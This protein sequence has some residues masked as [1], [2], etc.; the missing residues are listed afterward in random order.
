MSEFLPVKPIYTG[1]D[2]TALGEAAP[3]DVMLSPGGGIKFP[4]GSLQITAGGSG[5]SGTLVEESPPTA[6]PTTLWFESDSGRMYLKYKNPDDA[7]VW[8]EANVAGVRGEVGPAGEQGAVGPA[9]PQGEIGLTG[10]AGAD[11]VAGP[12]GADGAVG[13]QGPAGA[14]GVAGPAGADGA[15]GIQGE[16]GPQGPAGPADWYAIPNVPPIA[17]N[18]G[19]T[20]G[21]NITGSAGTA[22]TQPKSSAG[23]VPAST[24]FAK[25]LFSSPSVEGV[26]DWNDL[27]NCIPG[28]GPT[29][30]MGN[31]PNGPGGDNYY[32]S[33]CVEYAGVVGAGNV[34]QMAICYSAP[35]NEMYMRG[36]YG[37]VWGG[38]TR[39]LNTS[40]YT[41]YLTAGPQGPAGA[42]GPAGPQG[43]QGIPGD[44][45]VGV[46]SFNTR[47][48]AVVLANTDVQDLENTWTRPQTFVGNIFSQSYN[49]G[50]T[51]AMY[52]QDGKIQ[53]AI[54]ADPRMTIAG[55]GT[56]V[57]KGGAYKPGGGAW[58]DSS[59]ERIKTDVSPLDGALTKLMQLKPVKYELL[60]GEKDV[61]TAGFIAQETRA[62]FPNAVCETTPNDK[63]KEFIPDGEKIL[64]IGWKN[65]FFAYLVGAI[66]EQQATIQDLTARLAALE[67]K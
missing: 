49:L 13:P 26:A 39:F 4:D 53:F 63:E 24:Y 52:W 42:T 5:S 14:D 3:D 46:S 64:A 19:G 44:P 65:D 29:L 15:P 61:L 6:A 57:I 25:S 32:H 18:D 62:V 27:S 66:Q 51:E 67:N 8:V 7:E 41:S 11:G 36:R 28:V 45:A 37:D 55:D 48:G 58:A 16:V 33:F 10:P 56:F 35:A 21:I 59:D 30:L 23:D 50:P 38:W 2:V 12:A 40:N 22:P 54:A 17:Y 34:T 1:T 43:P 47:T 20:Y 31:A 9:G 60:T